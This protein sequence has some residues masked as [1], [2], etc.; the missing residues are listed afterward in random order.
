MKKQSIFIII[1][2]LMIWGCSGGFPTETKKPVPSDHSRL[3]GTALHKN[4]QR[5]PYA[6]DP[7]T[8]ESNCASAKCHHSD[9]RGGLSQV[10]GVWT[11][12][13]S[14]YECHGKLWSEI[15]SSFHK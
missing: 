2:L 10:N 12:A 1:M 11:T 13:P 5:E 4:G 15:D 8:G 9:L 7:V 3:I 6:F 14:C